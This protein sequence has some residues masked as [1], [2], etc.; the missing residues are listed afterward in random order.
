MDWGDWEDWL[1]HGVSF[2]LVVFWIAGVCAGW[3]QEKEY[4]E[5]KLQGLER[6]RRHYVD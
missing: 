6:V 4:G 5:K 2:A 3:F 1:I